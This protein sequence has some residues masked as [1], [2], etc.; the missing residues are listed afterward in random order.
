MKRMT[1]SSGLHLLALRF[2]LFLGGIEDESETSFNGRDLS[3]R[4]RHCHAG[5]REYRDGSWRLW[6]PLCSG[7]Q[8]LLWLLHVV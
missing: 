3:C 7:V 8:Q 6:L 5:Q 2:L 4:G 1:D